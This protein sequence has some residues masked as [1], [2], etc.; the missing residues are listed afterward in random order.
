MAQQN[1][2]RLIDN[3]ADATTHPE[4]I[5]GQGMKNTCNKGKKWNIFQQ[6]S[7]GIACGRL[8]IYALKK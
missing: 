4:P 2:S 5:T 3:I 6:S 8:C 1:C 7:V